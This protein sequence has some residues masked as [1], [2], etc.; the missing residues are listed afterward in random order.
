MCANCRIPVLAGQSG[1]LLRWVFFVSAVPLAG[2]TVLSGLTNSPAALLPT[3]PATAPTVPPTNMPASPATA[4]PTA[5]PVAKLA[6]RPPPNQSGL[7]FALSFY[8]TEAN[9]SCW[10][11]ILGRHAV[12]GNCPL[13][14]VWVNRFDD[15]WPL[16]S[17]R[18]RSFS[19]SS[20]RRKHVWQPRGQD[21]PWRQLGRAA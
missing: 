14:N 21:L 11:G 13:G 2:L 3:A 16:L 6:N 12:S 17:R 10:I 1:V 19:W 7:L 20:S 5:A 9:L 18:Y 4:A 8:R 15:F